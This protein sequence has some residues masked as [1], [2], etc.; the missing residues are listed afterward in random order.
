[1]KSRFSSS[2]SPV[3]LYVL[4]ADEH[5]RETNDAYEHEIGPCAHDIGADTQEKRAPE[6][7]VRSD[8]FGSIEQCA[9]H[10]YFS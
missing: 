4:V 9:L 7:S 10:L 1:M 3:L 6:E 5:E 2:A 8:V